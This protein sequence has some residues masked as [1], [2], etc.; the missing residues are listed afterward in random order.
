M[1]KFVATGASLGFSCYLSHEI[2]KTVEEVKEKKT[3]IHCQNRWQTLHEKQPNKFNKHV[4]METIRDKR[5][6]FFD[7]F[8]ENFVSHIDMETA[9]KFSRRLKALSKQIDDSSDITQDDKTDLVVFVQS[10]GG[11]VASVKM[12]CDTI[13]TF[14]NKHN[15]NFYVVVDKYAF[16]GG[17]LIAL[18]ADEIMM[19]DFA[20]LSRVDPQMIAFPMRHI[21]NNVVESTGLTSVVEKMAIGMAKDAMGTVLDICETKVKPKYDEDAYNNIMNT[22]L[23][24]EKIHDHTFSKNDCKKSGLNVTDIPKNLLIPDTI[25][26]ASLSDTLKSDT[27]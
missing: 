11:E 1:W 26:D 10:R 6:G 17:S 15:A 24:S 5:P 19:D 9:S 7:C 8:D 3:L 2:L 27:K 25:E 23:H 12:I 14:K 21:S 16:S 4:F 18:S 20:M 13:E 22:F